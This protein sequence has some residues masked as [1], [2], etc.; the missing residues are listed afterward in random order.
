[1]L[2]DD[3]IIRKAET[4]GMPDYDF[5]PVCPICGKECETF[6]FDYCGMTWDDIIA[7]DNCLRKMD[8]YEMIDKLQREEMR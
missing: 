7:C 5:T 4:E 3:P 1:M 2:P 6:Y 8:A